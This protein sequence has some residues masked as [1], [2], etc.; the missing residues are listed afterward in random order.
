MFRHY[1]VLSSAIALPVILCAIVL[2]TA[3]AVQLTVAAVKFLVVAGAIAY[4]GAGSL[5]AEVAWLLIVLLNLPFVAY[6]ALCSHG[7]L[8]RLRGTASPHG[9]PVE[10]GHSVSWAD[11]HVQINDLLQE[12][13]RSSLL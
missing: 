12:D 5:L 6:T 11:D 3:S 1:L 10:D 9:K 7:E 4:L 2:G 8:R 13:C